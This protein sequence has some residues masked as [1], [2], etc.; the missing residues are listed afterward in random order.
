MADYIEKQ[1]QAL[2]E[3]MRN[4]FELSKCQHLSNKE[5]AKRLEISESNVS[6]QIAN[7]LKIFRTK[8]GGILPIL[9]P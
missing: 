5:I 3:K 8:L 4:I 7:A 2:P 9:F 6:T 1:I